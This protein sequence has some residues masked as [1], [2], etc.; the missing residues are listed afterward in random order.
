VVRTAATTATPLLIEAPTRNAFFR[1][2]QEPLDAS[3]QTHHIRTTSRRFKGVVRPGALSMW[4]SIMTQ[5]HG[6]KLLRI[7]GI[8]RMDV[9]GSDQPQ[10]YEI[11]CVQHLLYPAQQLSQWPDD[12]SSN[13]M[14]FIA[15]GMSQQSLDSL[16]NNLIETLGLQ[17]AD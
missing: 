15:R 3:K 13:R 7:K 14:V 10:A 12:D 17:I 8:L 9:D 6:E 5:M 11:H 4:L 1:A 2:T 16:A